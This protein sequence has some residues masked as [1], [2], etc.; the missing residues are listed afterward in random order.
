MLPFLTFWF[1]SRLSIYHSFHLINTLPKA[2]FVSWGI[3]ERE[4]P[5]HGIF[6]IGE[7]Q[8]NFLVTTFDVIL[9]VCDFVWISVCF[10]SVSVFFCLLFFFFFLLLIWQ[11]PMPF[12]ITQCWKRKKSIFK[13]LFW[14]TIDWQR[15]KPLVEKKKEIQ[16]INDKISECCEH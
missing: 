11:E 1:R 12:W 6:N 16:V 9:C 15:W 4:V 7:A 3:N 10:E 5:K 13:W 8:I 14:K 2:H